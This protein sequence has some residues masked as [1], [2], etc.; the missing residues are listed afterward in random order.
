VRGV[1]KPVEPLTDG[2][3]INHGGFDVTERRIRENYGDNYKRLADL[4]K[5]YDPANLFRLNAN[6]KPA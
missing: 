2:F 6:I 1:W 3:Y 4:K 5:R